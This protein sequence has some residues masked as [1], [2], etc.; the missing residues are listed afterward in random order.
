MWV[1]KEKKG[2][3]AYLAVIQFNRKIASVGTNL[4]SFIALL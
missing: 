1:R 2:L 4:Y 3:T